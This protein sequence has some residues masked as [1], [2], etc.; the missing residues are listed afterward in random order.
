[1]PFA[2]LIYLFTLTTGT[3]SGIL[4]KIESLGNGNNRR[5]DVEL[6]GSSSGGIGYTIDVSLNGGSSIPI[7]LDTGSNQFWAASTACDSCTSAGM[8]SSGLEAESGCEVYGLTYGIG[9]VKG[10]IVESTMTVGE[11]TVDNLHALVRDLGYGSRRC[12]EAPVVGFHL[13]RE[14]DGTESKMTI[15]DVSSISYAQT[16]KK[17]TVPSRNNTYDLYQVS[18]NSISVNGKTLESDIIAYIDTG[19]TA[20]STPEMLAGDIYNALFDGVAYKYGTSYIVPCEPL[21]N[22]SIAFTFGGVAFDMA[23]EDLVGDDI[24]DNS[25]WCYGRFVSLYEGVDY[26]VIGDAFLHNVYHTVNVQ[27]GDVTFYALS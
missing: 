11:W 3:T 18:M 1:M 25:G 6:D 24:A 19:S 16:S 15:G 23:S 27:N 7:L 4:R 13:G 14:G 10:C 22:A 9:S 8:Q 17:V 12:N 26:M 21:T 2:L 20:I 5:R